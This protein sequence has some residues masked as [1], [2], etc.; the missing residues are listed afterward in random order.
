MHFSSPSPIMSAAAAAAT[1]ATTT[2]TTTTTTDIAFPFLLFGEH[3]TKIF[4]FKN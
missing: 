4:N 1:T 2:T 3:P